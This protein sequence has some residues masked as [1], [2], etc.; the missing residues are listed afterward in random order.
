MRDLLKDLQISL[1]QI[2]R[3]PAFAAVVILTL[4]L[5]IGA[6]TAIFSVVERVLLRPLP[7]DHPEELVVVWPEMVTNVR[8][9]EWLASNAPSLARITGVSVAD[10]ALTGEAGVAAERVF[11]ARVSPDHFDVMG[12]RAAMGRTFR[13][14]ESDPGRSS[15]V[16][17]D[18]ALWRGRYGGDP[19]IV[20]RTIQIDYASYTV[21]GVMPA[22]YLPLEARYRLWIPQEVEPGTT[23]GTDGTWWIPTRVARLAPG[24]SLGSAMSEVRAAASRLAGLYPTDLD[25]RQ[26]ALATV[27]PLQEAMVGSLGRALWIL[28]GA[29]ALVLLV[30]CANVAN[31]LLARA[32]LKRRDVAVRSALGSSRARVVWHL[33]VESLVLGLL[34]GVA[35]VVLAW[36]T[37]DALK[38]FSPAELPRI[39]DVRID[40]PV[41]L[42]ACGASLL[43]AL[44]FG[45]VPA[46]RATRFDI[47]SVLAG[48]GRGAT[49]TGG[50]SRLSSGLIA[51]EVAVSV[52]L[53]TGAGLMVRTVRNLTDVDPGFRA[54]GV[55]TM[56]LSAPPAAGEG[57]DTGGGP[58]MAEYRQLWDALA[59]L[60]GVEAVGGIHILPLGGGNNRYPFWA[61]GNEP[62]SGGRP[63]TANIRVATPGYLDAMRIPLVAGRWFATADRLATTPVVA[64]NRTLAERLWPGESAIGKR[65]RLLAADG[66]EWEVVGVI[67]DVTQMAL[68]RDPSGEIYLPHEQWRWGSMFAT[69]RTTGRP[70]ALVPPVLRTIVDLDPDITVSRVS[71]MEDIVGASIATNRFLA[72]LLGAF[73]LLALVLGA[74][75]VYGVVAYGVSRRVPEF[76]VRMALGSSGRDILGETVA[77]GLGP[78][79]VGMAVGIAAAWGA[80]RLLSA[81]LFGVEHTDPATYVGVALV[82]A[83]VASLASWI[84]ARRAMRIDPMIVLR[85]E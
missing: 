45:L 47:R 18:H 22:D 7:Y 37:L 51:T 54:D 15:V 31:L 61:E 20:G 76:A 29:V 40:G 11:G 5:G 75:G 55:L 38:S 73:G 58:D 12:A 80:T 42:F 36:G 66:I 4:A 17:I 59:A 74:V 85:G 19:D 27:A 62:P 46:L 6:N 43:T 70:E 10:F 50:G 56:Q 35:G 41:L 82:L 57:A 77:R 26:A 53:A 69:I 32:P 23:V 68:A 64:L 33:L 8:A 67:G 78:V 28:L 83:L 52:V 48:S 30:A 79:A 25:A 21:I 44:L 71:S 49:D 9:T 14:E 72:G 2:R 1:R 81:L 16:V 3:R 13:P 65:V 60:P 24:A 39:A 84:P 34:G 63:P